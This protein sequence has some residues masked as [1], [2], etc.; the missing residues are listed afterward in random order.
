VE[1]DAN[2]LGTIKSA[3]EIGKKGKQKHIYA[4]CPTCN[5]ER[6]TPIRNTMSRDSKIMCRPCAIAHQKKN[7]Q[8]FPKQ[9]Y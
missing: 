2:K 8:I 4:Q 3:M 6:W 7:W 5:L 9:T 1:N